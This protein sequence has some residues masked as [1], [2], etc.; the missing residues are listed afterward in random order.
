MTDEEIDEQYKNL[1]LSEA[2]RYERSNTHVLVAFSGRP[3][4]DCNLNW[5]LSNCSIGNHF[6]RRV[7]NRL[8]NFAVLQLWH[9]CNFVICTF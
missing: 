9:I 1:N 6:R 8:D 2:A 4:R 5:Q 3:L 7:R